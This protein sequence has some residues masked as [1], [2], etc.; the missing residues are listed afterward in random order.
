MFAIAIIM[1]CSSLLEQAQESCYASCDTQQQGCSS[2]DITGCY[3][4]CDWMIATIEEEEECLQLG[5]EAWECDTTMDWGCS[6]QTDIV[7]E[8]IENTCTDT[9][10]QFGLHGCTDR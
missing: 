10:E 7:G 6:F 4:L 5:M 8:P 2:L 9:Q 3:G 1:A